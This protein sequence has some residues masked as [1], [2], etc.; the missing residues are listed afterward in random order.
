[1][2]PSNN[3]CKQEQISR[4]FSFFFPAGG[5]C[6]AKQAS[7]KKAFCVIIGRDVDRLLILMLY[8]GAC[9]GAADGLFAWTVLLRL[10]GDDVQREA[11]S[12]RWPSM[13]GPSRCDYAAASVSSLSCTEMHMFGSCKKIICVYLYP[14][15]GVEGLFSEGGSPAP[16]FPCFLRVCQCSSSSGLQYRSTMNSVSLNVDTTYF[17][18]FFLCKI[19]VVYRSLV[20]ST[21]FLQELSKNKKKG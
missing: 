2:V 7:I 9:R 11:V 16:R 5:S 19:N 15:G 6:S 4:T 10:R 1:M 17:S 14:S 21:Y 3:Q 8:G 12:Q 13:P 20:N 18:L